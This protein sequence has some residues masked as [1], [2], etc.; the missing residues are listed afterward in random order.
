M[1]RSTDRRRAISRWR[2]KRPSSLPRPLRLGARRT[3]SKAPWTKLWG[4]GGEAR[5]QHGASDGF[6]AALVAGGVT[7]HALGGHH[8]FVHGE[9][10]AVAFGH[11]RASRVWRAVG[12]RLRPERSFF[13][14]RT[15]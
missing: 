14:D 10:V 4:G 15:P 11:V 5:F 12:L 9:V 3:P 7:Q 2:A 13:S 8:R 6:A 1:A